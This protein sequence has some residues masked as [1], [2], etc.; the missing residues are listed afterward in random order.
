[1]TIDYFNIAKELPLSK[2][3]ILL[4]AS[5]IR[6][7][8]LHEMSAG[9]KFDAKLFINSFKEQ[10]S[11]G[12]LL[13]HAFNDDI[14][15]GDTF[16]YKNSKP[17]TGTLSVAAW[18]DSDFIR[19]SDPF[20][21]FM[22][23]GKGTENL[24]KTDNV[25]TFGDNSVFEWLHQNKA[26][27]LIIDLPLIKSFT[28]VHY[29]EEKIKV[30]YRKHIKHKIHYINENGEKSIIERLFY[31]RKNGYLNFLDDL[32]KFLQEK[33]IA[34]TYSFNKS[35]FMLIDLAQAYDFIKSNIHPNGNL[36]LYKFSHKIWIRNLAKGVVNLFRR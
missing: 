15:S 6:Q 36:F 18:K 10:L 4:I 27:M 22:V 34:K 14:L 32:E 3:D 1:M 5:D 29:C 20:H 12:T 28:F 2:N 19:T 9:K 25:S 24:K 8:A 13:F 21:S 17:N 11:E 33:G 26:K 16:D 31:T 23:W 35:T 30:K 7:L